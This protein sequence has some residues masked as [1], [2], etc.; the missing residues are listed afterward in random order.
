M[1]VSHN[2]MADNTQQEE[3]SNLLRLAADL[4]MIEL[5]LLQRLEEC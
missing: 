1:H 3:H 2:P 5:S 4:N